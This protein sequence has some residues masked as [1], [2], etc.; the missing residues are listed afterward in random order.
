M[1][2]TQN[3]TFL[4]G[5]DI[6]NNY[7]P[8]MP[9]IIS[10]AAYIKIHYNQIYSMY[11][12][13]EIMNASANGIFLTTHCDNSSN[14]YVIPIF[15]RPKMKCIFN[16]NVAY[17]SGGA[18]YLSTNSQFSKIINAFFYNNQAYNLGGAIYF[19]INNHGAVFAGLNLMKNRAKSSGGGIYLYTYNSGIQI[20][21][22]SFI[23]N[24]ATFTGGAITFQLDNGTDEVD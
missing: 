8:T 10:E 4:G 19:G 23:S 20:Y 11:E 17:D 3:R 2:T 16:N 14:V 13:S 9:F 7:N 5:K 1:I 6:T 12:A 24:Y 18:I 21:N 15:N 22:S